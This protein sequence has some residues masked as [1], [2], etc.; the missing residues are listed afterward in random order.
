MN[1]A[2]IFQPMLGML[3]L[4]MGV[5]VLLYKR[6]IA[7]MKALRR[8]VQSYTTPENV[9]GVLPE[10]ANLPAH[11][12]RNLTEL[13]V[14]FYALCLYLYVSGQVDALYVAA[15]WVFFVL[16]VAH[17]IVHCSRNIVML[18]F[19]LYLGASLALWLMVLRAAWYVV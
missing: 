8:P 7:A 10:F 16:R 5:W 15:A 14:L 1:D 2:A 13:P 3:L 4:T 11:N 9:V 19:Y 17:S 18:R 6:R 12:L